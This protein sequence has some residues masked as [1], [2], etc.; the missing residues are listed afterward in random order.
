[1]DIVPFEIEIRKKIGEIVNL[2]DCENI[3]DIINN[4][5]KVSKDKRWSKKIKKI[6]KEFL[7]NYRFTQKNIFKFLIDKL[8]I[9]E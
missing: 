5:I 8:G 7:F 9:N 6:E 2:D 1:M 4:Y 3:V